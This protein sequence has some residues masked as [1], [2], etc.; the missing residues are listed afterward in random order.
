MRVMSSRNAR[1]H[2]AVF[3]CSRSGNRSMAL[4]VRLRFRFAIPQC[5]GHPRRIGVTWIGSRLRRCS[6]LIR[7]MSANGCRG[8][9]PKAT[10]L[11][12]SQPRAG[13]NVALEHASSLAGWSMRCVSQSVIGL[14]PW[15]VLDEGWICSG[16]HGLFQTWVLGQSGGARS[17]GDKFVGL[18]GS[19]KLSDP[20][21]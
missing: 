11:K 16:L 7:L 10:H 21:W 19:I 9:L 2:T 4:G 20:S 18:V 3:E 13:Q 1:L 8:L 17:P 12:D 14:A 6:F 5:C 15:Y